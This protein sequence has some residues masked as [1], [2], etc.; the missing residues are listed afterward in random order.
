[1]MK[2][3]PDWSSLS[4]H[5]LTHYLIDVVLTN[6]RMTDNILTLEH[7]A[8]TQANSATAEG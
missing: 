5:I 6:C 2:D 7:S 8:A 3:T 4:T 1:M